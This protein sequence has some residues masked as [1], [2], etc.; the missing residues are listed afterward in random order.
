MN[1]EPGNY[2]VGFVA[3]AGYTYTLQ[4][5]ANPDTSNLDSDVPLSGRTIQVTLS[6]GENDPNLDAGLWR[7]AKLGDYV[8]EDLDADG[9]QDAN[10]PGVN[11]VAVALIDSATGAVVSTT[12]TYNFLGVNGYYTFTDLIS[13]TYVVS[14]T[15]PAGYYFTGANVLTD[16]T[17][18]DARVQPRTR[19]LGTTGSYPIFPG[20]NNPTVDAGIVRPASL[21]DRV[22]L[23]LDRDGRQTGRRHGRAEVTVQLLNA[24]G[25]VISTTT[26][27]ANGYYTFSNLS[28]GDVCGAVYDSQRLHLHAPRQWLGRCG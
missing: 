1:L 6:P 4:N 24:A 13:G 5:N 21:G 14:F 20:D 15:A 19:W 12:T 26:T 7:P 17:D 27:D 8:W 10:E 22:W 28:P 25:S 11:G 2:S 23:D 9:Q 3:P 18:S 16:A